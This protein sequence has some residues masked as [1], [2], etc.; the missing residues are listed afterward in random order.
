MNVLIS[1]YSIIAV[2]LAFV[3]STDIDAQIRQYN[4]SQPSFT[5]EP[6]ISREGVS[7]LYAEA[8]NLSRQ[9]RFEDAILKYD[10]ALAWDPYDIETLMRKANL[11]YRIGRFEE[12]RQNFMVAK[13]VNPFVTEL[14]QFEHQASR[15]DIMA[16]DPEKYVANSDSGIVQSE[17]YQYLT[18]G[19]QKKIEG[20]I[21]GA[22]ND[23]EAAIALKPD[24]MA[25]LYK[26]RGNLYLLLKEYYAAEDDYTTALQ[27][28][29][30]FKEALHN[31][32]IARLL[33]NKR[34]DACLDFKNS[35]RLGFEP[36]GE[37]LKYLCSK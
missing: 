28:Q 20:N 34:I 12:A 18:E 14:F 7:R 32:G 36:S 30:E 37:P 3:L 21:L 15:L 33:G 29:P 8:E 16:F 31:R 27:L 26:L 1:K 6:T 35:H 23:I 2:L 9:G 19:V 4:M 24:N 17:A 10:N 22:L 5:N 25:T 11:L 13:R